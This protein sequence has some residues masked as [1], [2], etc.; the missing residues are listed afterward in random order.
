[1][2]VG[3][4]GIALAGLLAARQV[5][6]RE[7]T[8]EQRVGAQRAIEEVFW[9]HRIWPKDNPA[10]KPP[11]SAVMPDANLRDRVKDYLQK[12][13]ALE[14]R[15]Q[16]PIDGR[17]L[18]D[19]LNRMAERTRDPALLSE[20]FAALG[21]DAFVVA[22]TLGRQVLADRLIRS[23]QA[24]DGRIHAALKR[25]AE[26]ALKRARSVSDM[27]SLGGEYVEQTLVRLPEGEHG[28]GLPT[29]SRIELRN[30]EWRRRR[31][32]LANR[33]GTTV[34]ALPVGRLSGLDEDAESFSASAVL[35][36]GPDEMVV[37]SVVWKKQPFDG[38]WS[39]ARLAAHATVRTA[40]GE[41]L[42]KTPTAGACVDDTWDTHFYVPSARSSH[43][44]VWTGTEMIVWGGSNKAGAL[45]TGGRY[46]P[47]T[48]TWVPVSVGANVPGGRAEHTAIWTGTEMIL[49]GG[50]DHEVGPLASGGRYNPSTDSWLPTS[51]GT[52]R[53]SQRYVHTAVWT[54]SEMVI[55]GGYNGTSGLQDGGIYDPATDS[56][57]PVGTN[58]SL[59][60]ARSEHTA[61][62]TGSKMLV[63]GGDNPGNAP[64]NTGGLYDPSTD[65]WSATAVSAAVIG[66]SNHS[67]VWTGTE[68]IIWGGIDSTSSLS[69]GARYDPVAN[70]WKATAPGPDARSGHT[71]VWTGSTMII[72]G[73]HNGVRLNSGG[74]YDPTSD[75]WAVTTTGSAPTARDG[76]SAVWTGSEMIVWGGNDINEVSTGARYSPDSD[77]FVPTST[78]PNVPLPH[79]NQTAVWTGTGM[80]VWGGNNSFGI[81]SNT[82]G[83]YELATDNW[84]GTSMGVN[85]PTA[86]S[87]HT[88]V[89]TGTEMIVWGGL[90]G[91]NY[92]NSGGRYNPSSN[93]WTLTTNGT[94]VPS[95]RGFHSAVWT[96]SQ[97]I[98]WGGGY[99][100]GGRYNPASNSWLPTSTGTN[101][102]SSRS[103]QTAVWT[104]TEMIVWGGNGSDNSGGRYNPATDTW[105]ATSTGPNVPSARS[106]HTASWTGSDMV[107][108]GGWDSM[109][110]TVTNTGGRYHP[111]TDTWLPTSTADGTPG[112]R[113]FH[114]SV[115]TGTEMIIWAG[116][117]S[118][119]WF[120]D[121]SRY[122]PGGDLWT[123]M[124][125]TSA[126]PQPRTF[127]SAV[128]TGQEMIVWGGD[129]VDVNLSFYCAP[130]CASPATFHRDLDGD[131]FGDPAV[132]L[133]AC[134]APAGY[135][136]DGTDCNDNAAAVHPGAPEYCNGIDDNCNGVVDDGTVPGEV[137]GLLASK[138]ATDTLLTWVTTSDASRYD[139]LRGSV[140]VWP[141]GSNPGTE[142]CLANDDYI[143]RTTDASVPS[144][145]HAFWYVVRA[146]NACGIG[147]YG[148]Q[149]SHGVSTTPRTSTSCP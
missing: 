86:R 112:P 38:W 6:S 8:F 73:G 31:E 47:S 64:V 149:A 95:G 58:G 1:M 91:G 9:R 41:L 131:G 57:R 32:D 51:N 105:T 3:S 82:G 61:V 72:W 128:W 136:S 20:L 2:R 74:R 13:D 96:G 75:S 28:S 18:Q 77:S 122:I 107:V 22:E 48:D 113:E 140:G 63:W 37:A 99:N 92:V 29:E 34:E 17:Q 103:Q 80:I 124:A 116:G 146:E 81:S 5:H 97:M 35:S 67:A 143:T 27:K 43:T 44:A 30:D 104:G 71:A 109:S 115:W 123:P 7:L 94:N 144:F 14:T 93:T 125:V 49:W 15:W 138:S 40:T 66:R 118:S 53:P 135:V 100:T 50:Y 23:W 111:A 4:V 19:E 148:S 55:W 129:P 69:S 134:S 139:I 119:S 25:S 117:T 42:L 54:G 45:N 36:L 106:S 114:A 133:Q 88:A 83:V 65:T 79:Q 10:P 60:T 145:G 39:Q 78:G 130:S 84:T 126:T 121:G 87:Y 110:Q 70:G 56:W 59:P 102:P 141:V 24:S 90:S 62:W 26:Q 76:H 120:N 127:P 11:L 33:F 85:V 89:W 147:S 142:T 108:W 52:N 68:M 21:D 101:V 12:C 98:V 132:S 46:T 16:R 137:I